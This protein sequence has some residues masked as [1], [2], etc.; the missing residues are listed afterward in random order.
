MS[1]KNTDVVPHPAATPGCFYRKL[2]GEQ[3]SFGDERKAGGS[4]AGCGQGTMQ[5]VLLREP[6]G[7]CLPPGRFMFGDA[8]TQCHG[9]CQIKVL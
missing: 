6:G 1:G 8:V 2:V 9:Q 4:R 3:V 5:V 7:R